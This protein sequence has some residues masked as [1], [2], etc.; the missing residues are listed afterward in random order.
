MGEGDFV[1]FD[2]VLDVEPPDFVRRGR[3]VAVFTLLNRDQPEDVPDE[4]DGVD[5]G[6]QC[7][8]GSE[9][10]KKGKFKRAPKATDS[11]GAR[12]FDLE[13]WTIHKAG[14]SRL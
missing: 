12:S 13:S 10:A 1:R 7:Q 5:S 6:I 9:R 8:V 2:E 14:Q 11:G 4:E 3:V